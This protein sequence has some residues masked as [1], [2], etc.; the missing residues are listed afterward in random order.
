MFEKIRSLIWYTVLL[1]LFLVV[2]HIGTSYTV[3]IVAEGFS[4]MEP[5]LKAKGTYVLDRRQSTVRSLQKDDL[6]AFEVM[7]RGRLKRTFARVLASPGKT[8][9]VREGRL[10]VD[11]N[12]VA[13]APRRIA[14]LDTGLIVP[15]DT[16]FIG[17]DSSRAPDL[18]L[19]KRLVAYRAVLGRVRGK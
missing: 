19:A 3:A 8:V 11:G 5:T 4:Y 10:L 13:E 15:R 1:V 14:T 12:D 7:D 17:F 18:P 2:Y 16:V 9:S 6:I